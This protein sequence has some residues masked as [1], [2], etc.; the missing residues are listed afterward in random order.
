MYDEKNLVY[1]SNAKILTRVIKAKCVHINVIDISKYSTRSKKY[2]PGKS[3]G[4]LK[5]QLNSLLWF[6]PRFLPLNE[7]HIYLR[8]IL[9]TF[10]RC[11]F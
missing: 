3:A 7:C 10:K 4:V 11:K 1:K 6:L 8:F 2:M 5:R 9:K